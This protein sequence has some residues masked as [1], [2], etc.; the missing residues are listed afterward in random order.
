MHERK[1]TPDVP[2]PQESLVQRQ[3]AAAKIDFYLGLQRTFRNIAKATIKTE[4]GLNKRQRRAKSKKLASGLVALYLL[5]SHGLSE[6]AFNQGHP[7]ITDQSSNLIDQHMDDLQET[8][9]QYENNAGTYDAKKRM[10]VAVQVAH[11]FRKLSS[12]QKEQLIEASG[13]TP[14]QSIEIARK[15]T[16]SAAITAVSAPLS[17]A[18]VAAGSAYAYKNGIPFVHLGSVDDIATQIAVGVSYAFQYGWGYAYSRTNHSLLANKEIGNA[19][20][21]FPAVLYM[22]SRRFLPEVHIGPHSIDV[23]KASTRL[24]TIGAIAWQEPAV[25]ASLFLLGP[26]VVVARNIV[27]GIITGTQAVVFKR[28]EAAKNVLR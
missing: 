13:Y 11:R 16:K 27:G 23:P 25:V 28:S 6:E 17:G 3:V 21:I 26:Q 10:R 2:V 9:A 7:E 8:E 24:G 4:E 20:D 12:N 14:K 19:P 5:R 15:L 22:L 1:P 18:I